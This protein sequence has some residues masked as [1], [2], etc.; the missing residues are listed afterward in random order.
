MGSWAQPG[1][2]QTGGGRFGFRRASPKRSCFIVL[3]GLEAETCTEPRSMAALAGHS[4]DRFRYPVG[5]RGNRDGRRPTAV[6]RIPFVA[7]V[8]VFGQTAAVPTEL[9]TS[10][11]GPGRNRGALVRDIC[12]RADVSRRVRSPSAACLARSLAH[13]L[14]DIRMRSPGK[15]FSDSGSASRGDLNP[16]VQGTAK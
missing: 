2:T 7:I 16:F 12:T 5:G 10:S 15:P 11:V 9:G 4:A 14:A 6:S 3:A 13:G 8:Y 1:E